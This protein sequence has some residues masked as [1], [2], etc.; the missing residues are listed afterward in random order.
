M[1]DLKNKIYEVLQKPLLAGLATVT[2]DSRPWVRYVVM[3]TAEDLTVRFATFINARKV[4]QI[5]N[6]PEVHLNCGVRDLGDLKP[7]LQIQ[8][9][10]EPTTKEKER[11]TFWNDKLKEIFKG[12][13]DP[14]YAVII[15][16]PYRIE[17]WSPG[18]FEPE[19]WTKD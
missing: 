8:G 14:N 6:N 12:P 4:A 3:M 13:D 15:V 19:V 2:E 17:Y 5:R 9:L 7:W 1:S 11:H 18:K 10:A 16:K